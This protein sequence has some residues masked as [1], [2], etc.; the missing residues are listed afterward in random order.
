MKIS[1]WIDG[2]FLSLSKDPDTL[3]ESIKKYETVRLICLLC[4][5]LVLVVYMF[6]IFKSTGS[7]ENLGFMFGLVLLAL[8]VNIQTDIYT[9]IL[10]LQRQNQKS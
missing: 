9:K 10:K 4:F 6:S 1:D 5:M 7:L 8:I 3:D 2:W